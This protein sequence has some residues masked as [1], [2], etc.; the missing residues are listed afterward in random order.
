MINSIK[1][2]GFLYFTCCFVPA[3][4]QDEPV[5]DAQPAPVQKGFQIGLYVGSYFA[6][7][8]TASLHDGYGVDFDGKRNSFENSYMYNKIV[9]QNGGG[10]S[11]Q[12]DLI[13]QELNVMHGD[14]SFDESDMPTYMRYQPS[15][16]FG[17]QCRYSVDNKNII[18]L[19]V[20]AAKL[21]SNGS[22]TITTIPQYIPGQAAQTIHTFKIKGMEQRLLFQV[23]FQH[24]FGDNEKMNFLLEGGLNVTLAKLDKNLIQI[25]NLTI[26][27]TS[28]YYTPGSTAYSVVRRVGTGFG[29]F[30]GAGLNL[31]ASEAFIIQLV[32]NP[33][34]E[35]INLGPNPKLKLQNSVGLRAYYKL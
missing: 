14:W 23:G 4:A 32:Y 34:Y 5:A 20:N 12:P 31:N 13:A 24:L 30:G 29:A 1:I 10:Y 3:F 25:N 6:N 7:N 9:L 16:M 22:F 18:L 8:Y 33:T 28:Y 17:L 11:G 27:L 21:T 19:N 26:D 2:A 35:G 15:F